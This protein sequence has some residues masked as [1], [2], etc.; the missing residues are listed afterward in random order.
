M[1]EISENNDAIETSLLER[2]NVKN[3]SVIGSDENSRKVS[4]SQSTRE[5]AISLIVPVYM[6]EKL[7]EHTLSVYTRD[8]R[9]KYDFELIV[10]DGG[11]SDKSIE[12]ARR[13]ADKVVIH[14]ENRRQTI[15]E[16]RNKGAEVASGNVFVFINGDTVPADCDSFFCQISKWSKGEA[17][18]SAAGALACAVNVAPNEKVAKDNIFYGFHNCYVRFL[19]MLGMGM[20]RGECQIVR[21]SIFKEVGG[22]NSKIAAGEDFDLF[23]RIAKIAKVSYEKRLLV[24]E[25]PR[26]FRKYGYLRIIGAWT[27]NSLSVMFFNRSVSD[28]WEAVR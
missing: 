6:E 21:S 5:P 27:L 23:R 19:N 22:Y 20:G 9:K 15:A 3:A 18:N 14:S 25:S 8:L 11:S 4:I 2:R 13:H 17:Q 7:L 16:G 28:E 10:S 1:R 26:R 12:I 24:Y